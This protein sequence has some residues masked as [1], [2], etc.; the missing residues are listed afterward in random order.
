MI[1]QFLRNSGM[2][3]QYSKSTSSMKRAAPSGA[4][5]GCTS[6]SKTPF[7]LLH[8]TVTTRD[9]SAN[10]SG[11]LIVGSSSC[12]N[13][14]QLPSALW[15]MV[16]RRSVHCSEGCS[17]TV[18]SRLYPSAQK[19]CLYISSAA[20]ILGITVQS[21]QAL[22][23]AVWFCACFNKSTG[24]VLSIGESHSRMSFGTCRFI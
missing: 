19:R 15:L 5:S 3:V 16:L 8:S 14:Q 1:H 4:H 9:S 17:L 11:M 2:S 13:D 23:F 24:G 7:V 18:L 22:R 6:I 12:A 21:I 10:H 20:L